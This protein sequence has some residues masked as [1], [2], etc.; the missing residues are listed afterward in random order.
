MQ[1]KKKFRHVNIELKCQYYQ[2]F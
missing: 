1:E 2:W